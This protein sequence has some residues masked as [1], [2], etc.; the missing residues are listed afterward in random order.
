[1]ARLRIAAIHTQYRRLL[2]RGHMEPRPGK[3]SCATV[4]RSLSGRV[5]ISLCSPTFLGRPDGKAAG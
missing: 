5:G 1:M 2:V 4:E 3:Y